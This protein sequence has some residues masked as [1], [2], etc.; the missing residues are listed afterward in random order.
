MLAYRTGGRGNA[1]PKQCSS[2][3]GKGWSY[4]HSQV[5]PHV[6]ASML[7]LT[8]GRFHLVHI[9]LDEQLVMTVKAR[10]R[11]SRPKTREA[12]LRYRH[13]LPDS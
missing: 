13:N 5:R 6:G 10:A 2:C 12:I 9:A 1:K 7:Q 3:E 4:I 8:S 11:S